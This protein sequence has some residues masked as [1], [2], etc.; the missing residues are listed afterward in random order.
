[1]NIYIY[2]YIYIYEGVWCHNDGRN[3]CKPWRG[4]VFK[5][6]LVHCLNKLSTCQGWLKLLKRDYDYNHEC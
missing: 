4:H 5:R 1:M 6:A 3:I 2:I